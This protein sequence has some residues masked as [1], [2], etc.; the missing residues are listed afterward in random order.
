MTWIAPDG[1]TQH[2]W[3]DQI[4][5]GFGHVT[6]KYSG[7]GDRVWVESDGKV[8][9]SIDLLTSDF[10]SEM[11]QQHAWAKMGSGTT[12]DA[13]FNFSLRWLLYPL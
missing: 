2:F 10:R 9:A 6:I 13:G 7:N 5:A 11:H 3:V 8:G 1:A 4:H 12:L